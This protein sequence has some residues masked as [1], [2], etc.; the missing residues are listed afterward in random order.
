MKEGK[1]IDAMVLPTN[2][3]DRTTIEEVVTEK[4]TSWYFQHPLSFTPFPLILG[5]TFRM[6]GASI[7]PYESFN[8]ALHVGDE[9]AH[10]IENRRSV[11]AYLGVSVERLTCANQVH[12]LRVARVDESH[13]GAGALSQETA[14]ADCDAMM[15]NLPSVPLLLFTADCVPLCIYDTK[16][17][18]VAVIHAGWKGTIGML[19]TITLEAMHE[20]YGTQAADCYVFLGPSIGLSSFEVNEELA[21]RFMEKAMHHDAIVR[22]ITRPG[23][24]NATPHVDLWRFIIHSLVDKGVPINQITKSGIDSMTCDACFSYRREQGRTGRMA[25]FA[26]LQDE[27]R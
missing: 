10:V 6:G 5:S 18:A 23:A 22:Y 1:K 20:A 13:I 24:S 21:H 26:M 14:L 16:H 8:L 12:G 2:F 4:G 27:K 7:A 19:P 9:P 17:R 25:L 15:T 11:A 3:D